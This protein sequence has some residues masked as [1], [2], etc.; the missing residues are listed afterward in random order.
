MKNIAYLCLPYRFLYFIQSLLLLFCPYFMQTQTSVLGIPSFV[1]IF[2]R[3]VQAARWL[4]GKY[5]LYKWGT[6]RNRVFLLSSAPV[7]TRLCCQIW[8]SSTWTSTL[9]KCKKW[10]FKWIVF[11]TAPSPV[12]SRG[13]YTHLY[14]SAPS[15]PCHCLS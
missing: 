12:I 9:P 15:L 10:I 1:S 13:Y 3:I 14:R 2:W 8:P 4:A 6:D 11:I 7:T 5:R